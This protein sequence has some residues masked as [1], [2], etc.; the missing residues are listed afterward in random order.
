MKKKHRS[1]NISLTLA[2]TNC[3]F[4]AFLYNFHKQHPSSNGM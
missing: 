2:T 1:V 3:Y 4:Y